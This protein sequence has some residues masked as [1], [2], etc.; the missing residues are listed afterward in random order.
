LVPFITTSWRIRPETI[1]SS[2]EYQR[3][4]ERLKTL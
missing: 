4:S 1:G 3:I 2:L